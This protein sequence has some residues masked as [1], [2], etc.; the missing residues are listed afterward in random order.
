MTVGT[1]LFACVRPAS[2]L[3]DG[4]LSLCSTFIE[5][6][7]VLRF[8]SQVQS[9][10]CESMMQD[11]REPIGKVQKL[12]TICVAQLDSGKLDKSAIPK[13]ELSLA[14]EEWEKVASKLRAMN[15]HHL[16]MKLEFATI[17]SAG[18]HCLAQAQFSQAF[19][20]QG[21]QICG[22]AQLP[23]KSLGAGVSSPIP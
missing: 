2:V 17:V 12:F 10:A 9:R 19:A 14:K 16:H 6:L 15:L 18:V 8:L 5:C 3:D 20:F 22:R 21:R 7:F 1:R 13:E 11:V 23:E 4:R